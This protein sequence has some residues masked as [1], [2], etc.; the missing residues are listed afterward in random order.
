[1]KTG[2]VIRV[3][4]VRVDLGDGQSWAEFTPDNERKK[5]NQDVF[6]LLVLGIEP[7]LIK[8]EGDSLDPEKLLNAMGWKRSKP[9][10]AKKKTARA[11]KKK[12]AKAVKKKATRKR[13]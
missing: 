1:M 7:R 3:R 2:D 8:D 13:G 12:T 10:A 5:D 9:K 6:V 4:R 11:A